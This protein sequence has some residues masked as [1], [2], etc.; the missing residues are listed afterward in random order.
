LLL[1]IWLTVAGY[2]LRYRMGEKATQKHVRLL[3]SQRWLF[4]AL[5]VLLIVGHVFAEFY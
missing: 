2:A 3:H 4:V 1:V 5:L